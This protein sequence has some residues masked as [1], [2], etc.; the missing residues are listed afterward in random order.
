MVEAAGQ[1]ASSE[2]EAVGQDY[3]T[4]MMQ[5]LDTAENFKTVIDAL[6]GN[7]LPMNERFAELA[8][9][10][11]EDDAEKTP[12][13]VL[14]MVQPVIMMTEEGNVDSGIGQL[15]QSLTGEV[16]MMTADGGLTDMGQGV[17]SLMV[18]NQAPP[19]QQFA[20]GGA[21]QHF[22]YGDGVHGPWRD[23]DYYRDA[24]IQPFN[25]AGLSSGSSR[26]ASGPRT[27][28]ETDVKTLFPQYR[29]MYRDV[30]DSEGLR[31]QTQSGI[32]FDVAQFGLNLAGGV[33]PRTGE[34]MTEL[35]L[36]SQIATAAHGLPQAVSEKIMR[37]EEATRAGDLAALDASMQQVGSERQLAQQ[38]ESREALAAEEFHNQFII[39]EAKL[40]AEGEWR[41]ADR[42]SD[43]AI[44]RLR[45]QWDQYQDAGSLNNMRRMLGDP[46]LLARYAAGELMPDF[47]AAISIVFGQTH[48]DARGNT[49]RDEVPQTLRQ[50][51][52][53]RA[54]GVR[55]APQNP[56][57]ISVPNWL[58][59]LA[60]G[61]AVQHLQLGGPPDRSVVPP[62]FL[63]E[64]GALL[65]GVTFDP[66]FG[67]VREPEPEPEEPLTSIVR[68]RQEDPTTIDLR[69]G[70]GPRA[71]LSRAVN[72]LTEAVTQGLFG[73]DGIMTPMPEHKEAISIVNTLANDA[74]RTMLEAMSVRNNQDLQDDVAALTTI[75][76][77]FWT[78]LADARQQS[79]GHA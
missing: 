44:A 63:D 57:P 24:Y 30:L 53:E 46:N 39:T 37:A 61:G 45:L 16:D 15:M 51:A 36:A 72:T 27:A 33:D 52:R 47:E 75:G 73:P 43:E 4:E 58:T 70:Y 74:K 56:V 40:R 22:A 48:V 54:E 5:S 9:Y 55:P 31:K 3:V 18:A 11:G 78:S 62:E 38:I 60:D 13:S 68:G 7:K 79:R 50:A 21:V 34:S 64:S 65:P 77:R 12:E 42:L 66:M 29:D 8:E 17:G 28:P 6:R 14:A 19:P 32:M 20:N 76:G 25:T 23:P 67:Y 10:V 2:M 69:K 59:G 71:V 35:P 41:A 26:L 1:M 49:V